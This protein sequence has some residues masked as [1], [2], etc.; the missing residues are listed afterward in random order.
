M[1]KT[2]ILISF[3]AAA[4]LPSDNLLASCISGNCNNGKGTYLFKDGSKYI[5]T[6]LRSQ[7]HGNGI[8]YL[9]DGSK[10][11]GEFSNG[12]KNGKGKM[13]FATGD[14]YVGNFSSGLISGSGKM[15][16]RNGDVYTGYWVNGKS[17]GKG[18]YVFSDGDYY[19]GGFL[20]G[21]FSGTGKL[22]RKDGSYYEGEWSKSK[23][24]GEGIAYA[25]GKK[26]KHKYHMN[27]L[28]QETKYQENQES[29]IILTEQKPKLKDCT[30]QY[31]NAEKGSF[32]YG[33]GSVY[34]GD[35][36]NG[37]GSGLGICKYANGDRYEGGWQ[38]H[39]PHGKGTMHFAKGTVYAAIWNDGV[40][41]EKIT[42]AKPKVEI[43]TIEPTPSKTKKDNGQT[44]IFALIVGVASY[45]HMQSLKYTDDDA[46]Q[47]YAFLKS[48][49]GGAIPDDNIK[50]LID[51]A[52]TNK[53]IS[54]EIN[55]IV[56]KADNNDVVM[57]YLS[58]H[59]LD[60]AFVPS[61]FDGKKGHMAYGQIL[62]LLNSSDAKHKLFITDACHSGSMIASARTPWNVAVEKFYSAYNTINGG[63]AIMMSSKK[64][65]V[66]LE[67]GGLRQGIFSHFLIKGLKGN[68]DKNSD[69]LITVTELYD[70]VSTNVKSYTMNAQNPEIMGDFDKNMPVG[71]IR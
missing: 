31:C 12:D 52:A 70:Y 60:G 42:P 8:F 21:E 61:D 28:L 67:Y 58:G 63:T 5:G 22:V 56:S 27:K 7:P 35:F 3:V 29:T 51:D 66:S 25:G 39:A 41:V 4:I 44:E 57:L 46:Y 19:V 23:K 14:V 24:H 32:R 2:I 38:N 15:V 30:K 16:Y 50:I 18:R 37:E 10:Y 64:E 69:K 48:P 43:A 13:S 55:N 68:A 26:M 20:D 65:E 36:V 34:E 11:E 17:S 40:P 62:D 53:S 33:D 9:S 71:L 59:G 54:Q 1:Y 45:N 49:E 6:F 47:L